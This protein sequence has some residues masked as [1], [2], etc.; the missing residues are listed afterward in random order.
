VKKVFHFDAP[1]EP[2]QCDAAIVWCFDNRFHLSFTKFVKRLG[3][4]NSDLIKIAGGAKNLASPE[5]ESDREFVLEQIRKSIVLHQTKRVIL[6]LHSD[7][8]AYGGL[9]GRF[10]GNTR[11]EAQYQDAELRRAADF[12]NKAIP[13]MEVQ[14][15]FVD[16][17]GVWQVELAP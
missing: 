9:M 10:G 7:C 4:S 1:R 6:M 5:R 12:L 2:Y 16:F 3:I 14:A 17:E 11:L 15:Y 8:G 13:G